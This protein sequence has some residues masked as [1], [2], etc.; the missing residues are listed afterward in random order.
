MAHRAVMR[1]HKR[2]LQLLEWTSAFLDWY[3]CEDSS[4]ELSL[5]EQP[6][7]WSLRHVYLDAR[8][9]PFA[10][11]C[12]S[13]LDRR[14]SLLDAIYT[15]LTPS[16]DAGLMEY[17]AQQEEATWELFQWQGRL[18]LWDSRAT[19][20]FLSMSHR[21]VGDGIVGL[22]A[23]HGRPPQQFVG[24]TMSRVGG[25]LW[26]Q[27][28]WFVETSSFGYDGESMCSSSLA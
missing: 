15:Y 21:G 4:E 11:S 17:H 24:G 26:N 23:F 7:L 9:G 12:F 6:M 18:W 13:S 8:F 3:E 22:L 20:C 16:L 27:A 28:R 2:A 14:R 5:D 10:R 19:E 25:G 1:E